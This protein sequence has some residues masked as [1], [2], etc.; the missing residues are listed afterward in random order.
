MFDIIL[1]LIGFI[2]LIIGSITDLDR[3]EVPDWLNYAL[4]VLGIIIRL[5]HSINEQ[6]WVFIGG[7]ILGGLVAYALGMIMYYSGQWGGGDTKMLIA[8]GVLFGTYQ[9]AVFLPLLQ[10][11]LE[12][13]LPAWAVLYNMSFLIIFFINIIIV[14]AM[15]GVLWTCVKAIQH[16]KK[17]SKEFKI[18]Y[19]TNKY[20]IMRYV[21]YALAGFFIGVAVFSK[22]LRIYFALLAILVICIYYIMVSIKAIE[23]S[24]MIQDMKT[25][26]LTEGE[27]I[28]K[29]IM[30]EG[31]YV[32][33]PKDLGI[34]NEQIALLKKYNIKSVPVKIGIP[35]IPAFL[36]AFIVTIIWGNVYYGLFLIF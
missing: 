15:Y 5:I 34:S 17:F 27:W 31:K 1:I 20:L 19:K 18:L 25:S 36:L 6:S 28:V 23:K 14:G 26:D 13:M 29:D 2:G 24:S 7:A 4:I 33:G 21:V 8:L 9:P 11:P 3:R 10:M 16:F 35:F 12:S 32:C 22:I 30:H